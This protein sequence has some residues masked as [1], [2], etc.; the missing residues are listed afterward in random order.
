M[1]VFINFSKFIIN[2]GMY[3]ETQPPGKTVVIK[4][5]HLQKAFFVIP[6]VTNNSVT[7]VQGG[8]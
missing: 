5:I 3:F 4:T 6:S 2:V 1:S 8:S 7:T